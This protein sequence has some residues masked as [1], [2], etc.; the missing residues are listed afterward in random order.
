MLVQDKLIK[1]QHIMHN[2][3]SLD[4][5]NFSNILYPLG[6]QGHQTVVVYFSAS[7]CLP[8]KSMKPVFTKLSEYFQENNIIFGI[9]DIAQ[10]PTLAPQYGIKSVPTIAVFQDTRLIDIIAGEMPFNKV[11]MELE[12]TLSKR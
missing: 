6:S 1:R 2:I 3:L 11:L 12:K 4:S 7:W 9:V 8:C 5:D 10:S